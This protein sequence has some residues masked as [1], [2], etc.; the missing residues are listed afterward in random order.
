MM[1]MKKESAVSPVIGVMLMLVVTILISAVVAGF[2]SN[3]ASE[4]DASPIAQ[5]QYVGVI[6]GN[7]PSDTG[8]LG[9]VGLVFEHKGGKQISLFDLQ[10]DLKEDIR[11]GG[12]ETTIAYT[13]IPSDTCKNHLAPGESRLS[14]DISYRMKKI[15]VNANPASQGNV[16]INPGDR[17]IV[18]AD[19]II[20]TL[21]SYDSVYFIAERGGAVAYS[22][23]EFQLGP[24]TLFTLTDIKSGSVI[25]SGD[26]TGQILDYG[27][28]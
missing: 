26:L 17:F 16:L 4:T 1:P 11:T 7:I 8:Y 24:K 20:S 22:E 19:R 13:D 9:E 28:W 14:S 5:I 23:G 2:A 12:N 15:G 21:N 10:L 3:L 6:E 25:S 18:Y 27:I